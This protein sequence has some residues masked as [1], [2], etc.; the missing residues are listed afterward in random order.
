H[1]WG[2]D[3]AQS[4]ELALAQLSHLGLTE[5]K[6]TRVSELVS[7]LGARPALIKDPDLAVLCDAERSIL[8]AD[9]RSYRAYA[10]AL[11]EECADSPITDILSTRIS[12]LRRW[13]AQDRLFLTAATS[14]WEGPA[15]NN[16][17][18][19]LARCVKELAQ[20]SAPA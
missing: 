8:A 19:E 2:E 6:A 18:A 16:I 4:A 1:T 7:K 11:R 14:V 10:Q 12:V 3:E 17:R 5:P 15:R 20:L 9:P 13:L